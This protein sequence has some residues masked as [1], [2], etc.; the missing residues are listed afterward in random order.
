[1]GTPGKLIQEDLT[2][3][4]SAEGRV[5]TVT[6][7]QRHFIGYLCNGWIQVVWRAEMRIQAS[8][9]FSFLILYKEVKTFMANNFGDFD[10]LSIQIYWAFKALSRLLA[11]ASQRSLQSIQCNHQALKA[12]HLL[13]Y[14]AS[15]PPETIKHQSFSGSTRVEDLLVLS[16][17]QS[18]GVLELA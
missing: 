2:S 8:T 15:Q 11:E 16:T 3:M 1:M 14:S 13:P 7:W 17:K 10:E 12:L 4:R 18:I 9:A 6:A 5:K